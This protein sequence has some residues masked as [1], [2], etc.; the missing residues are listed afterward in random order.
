MLVK[1]I[2]VTHFSFMALGAWGM[3]LYMR[4]IGGYKKY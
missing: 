3:Y 1:D 2:L 4:G